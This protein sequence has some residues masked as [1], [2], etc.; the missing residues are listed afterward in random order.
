MHGRAYV[1]TGGSSGIGFVVLKKLLG[2]SATVH[3][4]DISGQ[5]PTISPNRSDR[6]HFFL[7]VDISS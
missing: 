5:S 6:L 3:A 1:V 2:L 7:N 4:I